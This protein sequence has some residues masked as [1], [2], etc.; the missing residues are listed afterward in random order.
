MLALV[1]VLAFAFGE[2][3]VFCA[4]LKGFFDKKWR[5]SLNERIPFGISRYLPVHSVSSKKNCNLIWFHAASVGEVQG[6]APLIKTFLGKNP[7][8]KILITTTS[9]TG[10]DRAQDI[11]PSAIIRLAPLDSYFLLRSF[12]LQHSPSLLIINE[13][14]IWPN[15]IFSASSFG[16]PIC[17]VNARISDKSYPRYYFFRL[18]LGPLFS[19]MDKIFSQ[20]KIDKDRLESLG[21]KK[22][23]VLG[24]TK[25]DVD[26]SLPSNEKT[27]FWDSYA[28]KSAELMVL[29]AGSVREEEEDI[30]I[31]AFEELKKSF[32]ELRLII[33]P[34]HPE[35]FNSV[36]TKLA[37]NKISYRDR[38]AFNKNFKG[39]DSVLLLDTIG[40]LLFAYSVCDIAFV[41]GTL[42]LVGGH[43]ILEPAYFSK[44]ILTGP[45]LM[46]VRSISELLLENQAMIIVQDKSELVA[47]ISDLLRDDQK[48]NQNGQHANEVHLRL[49]GVSMLIYTKIN[50]L[51]NN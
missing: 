37:K 28:A 7:S 45:Y 49:K 11:F 18:L 25:Y 42:C 17:I 35:R 32:P 39:D 9:L 5:S 10:K 23:E 43:N 26:V 22:V 20:S 38:R 36:A 21:A 24:S 34:R 50:S 27:D 47:A 16:V 30:I 14:E 31:S 2:C 12:L 48:R 19:R 6:I 46:N 33:A 41:G 8:T 3:L 40:E 44:P 29:T 1:R 51:V 13:T 4:V 15:M